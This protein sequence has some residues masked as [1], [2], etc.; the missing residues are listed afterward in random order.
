MARGIG[1]GDTDIDAIDGYAEGR[2]LLGLAGGD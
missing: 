1:D 2:G